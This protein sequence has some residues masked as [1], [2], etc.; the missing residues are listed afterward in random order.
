MEPYKNNIMLAAFAVAFLCFL[1]AALISLVNQNLLM[2][3]LTFV[4]ALIMLL[5]IWIYY[6]KIP[7]K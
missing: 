1:I 3:G 4:V 2:A 7:K 5:P 6:N